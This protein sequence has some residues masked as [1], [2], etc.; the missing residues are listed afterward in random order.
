M[1]ISTAFGTKGLW[2][3][4]AIQA[5]GAPQG[6]QKGYCFKTLKPLLT[7]RQEHGVVAVGNDIYLIGGM[8]NGSAT[9]TIEVYNVKT[10]SSSVGPPMPIPYHH[11]NL[12]V[13]D[14]KVYV[15]GGI[16]GKTGWI[17]SV[18]SY[19]LDPSSPNKKWEE[20]ADGPIPR[21]SAVIGVHGK[22]VWLAGGEQNKPGADPKA[23]E[24]RNMLPLDIVTSYDTVSNKW[25]AHENIPLPEAREHT[26]GAVIDNIFY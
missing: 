14:G 3:L 2:L 4:Y 15:L 11:P 10:D 12:A 24:S 19:R 13:V 17:A 18:K 26:G 16:T 20:I 9:D 7:P 23:R 25:T 21:G 6:A 5:Q 8:I 1:K 22:T